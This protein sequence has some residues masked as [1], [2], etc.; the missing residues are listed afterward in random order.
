MTRLLLVLAVCFGSVNAAWS[1]PGKDH[2]TPAKE[3]ALVHNVL[4]GEPRLDQRL[5]LSEQRIPLGELLDRLSTKT[6]VRLEAD[7]RL[8]PISGYELTIVVR[9]QPA[10]TLLEELIRLYSV[11]P[12]RWYWDRERRG[13]RT[14]YV[15]HNSQPAEAAA[16]AR[17]QFSKQFVL[18]Q[19]Q[20]MTRFYSLPP[21]ERA[22]AAQSD[23][24]LAVL[25][26][27]RHFQ[28]G[29]HFFSFVSHL[30]DD[31]LRSIMAGKKLEIPVE[32]LSPDQRDFIRSEFALANPQSSDGSPIEG[33]D[34][35]QKVSLEYGGDGT[36]YLNMGAVG[37]H[38]VLGGIWS[39]Q[40][41]HK[42]AVR[43]WLAEE[44]ST[45]APDQTVPAEGEKP[46]PEELQVERDTRDALLFRLARLGHLNLLYDCA[47][48]TR[49]S[50]YT[51]E[52]KLAGPLATVLANLEQHEMVIWKQH[53]GFLLLRRPDWANCMFGAQVPWPV[54]R[55]LRA[56]AA[57]HGEYLVPED[58]LRVSAL[59]RDQLDTLGEEFPDASYVGGN[60]V[61]IRLAVGMTQRERAAAA[62]PEGIGWQ[63]FS[64]E[65]QRRLLAL[66]AREDARQVRLLLQWRI[67]QQPGQLRLYLGPDVSPLRPM[68]IPFQK[69]RPDKPDPGHA[70]PGPQ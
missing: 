8:A 7:D 2:P 66:F 50:Q 64:Q 65:T 60:Q 52:F 28:R 24:F 12:D 53:E 46:K 40:E 34:Q 1:A 49:N 13:G 27:G 61:A 9:D 38:G 42:W 11:P 15:L 18:D 59:T 4:A 21:Q 23:P 51:Q 3:K 20:Q 10:R 32:K 55:D 25:N 57:A 31:E 67:D 19:R 30:S 56:S 35:L 48:G 68:E 5:S 70:P 36:I 54:R 63:E 45:H 14:R 58:W 62:R 39:D 29:V 22:A 47:P 37:G 26:D 44:D 41:L 17:I 69:R 6:G 43:Q 16:Q 33:P